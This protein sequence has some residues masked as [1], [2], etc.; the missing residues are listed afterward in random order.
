MK[1][2]SQVTKC[3]EVCSLRWNNINNATSFWQTLSHDFEDK[4]ISKK[5]V[6]TICSD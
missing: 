3:I 4:I 1:V 6:K 5:V 2:Q